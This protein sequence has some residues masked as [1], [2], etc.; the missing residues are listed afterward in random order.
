MQIQ[1]ILLSRQKLVIILWFRVMYYE[2]SAQHVQPNAQYLFPSPCA[3]TLSLLRRPPHHRPFRSQSP[4]QPVDER[5]KVVRR[6]RAALALACVRQGFDHVAAPRRRGRGLTA[7][8][9]ILMPAIIATTLMM[10]RLELGRERDATVMALAVRLRGRVPGVASRAE[11]PREVQ[12]LGDPRLPSDSRMRVMFERFALY[13]VW[14]WE[15]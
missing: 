14:E 8:V 1:N 12:L 7:V 15:L 3:Y 6:G 11:R 5:R 10:V 13:S 9:L 2:C 4:N